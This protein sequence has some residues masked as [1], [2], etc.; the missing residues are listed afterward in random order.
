MATSELEARARQIAQQ[1]DRVEDSTYGAVVALLE[2]EF[3]VLA[4]GTPGTTF[5]GFAP[6]AA[7]NAVTHS[8]ALMAWTSLLRSVDGGSGEETGAVRSIE[9]RRRRTEWEAT[10]GADALE[11]VRKLA[12]ARLRHVAAA[13][14]VDGGTSITAE[15]RE[16]W[17]RG[18]A[19]TEATR[20]AS[21]AQLDMAQALSRAGALPDLRKIW[22][23]RGDSHVRELHRKLHG[24]SVDTLTSPFWS[25]GGSQQLGFPGDPRAPLSEVLNCRCVM[26]FAPAASVSADDVRSSLSPASLGDEAFTLAAS[27]MASDDTRESFNSTSNTSSR[28][29]I[30]TASPVSPVNPVS[31]PR[32]E[33]DSDTARAVGALRDVTGEALARERHPSAGDS[34]ELNRVV[35][36]LDPARVIAMSTPAPDHITRGRDGRPLRD[37]HASAVL[38]V[39]DPSHPTMRALTA[40][41][42]EAMEEP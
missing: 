6:R 40:A 34:G 23:S 9:A 11:R 32:D 38:A 37:A 27:V 21:Q 35:P 8:A 31:E 41:Y 30:E 7:F 12:H 29:S 28:I 18:V 25:W 4:P 17:A 42:A 24:E 3:P 16:S 22:I 2:D 1:R 13:P 14:A 26:F 39:T 20:L 15:Q 5:V 36:P 19:R 33:R 10:A